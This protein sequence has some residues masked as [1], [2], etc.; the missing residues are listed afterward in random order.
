MIKVKQ[1][2]AL[3]LSTARGVQ[4]GIKTSFLLALITL[5][6]AAALMPMVIISRIVAKIINRGGGANNVNALSL[7]VSDMKECFARYNRD[8]KKVMK[9]LSKN[10]EKKKKL[11]IIYESNS[12]LDSD[13]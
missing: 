9:L 11:K 3:K 6:S 12:S 13:A 7:E 2:L 5:I 1:S 10:G 8:H 4:N